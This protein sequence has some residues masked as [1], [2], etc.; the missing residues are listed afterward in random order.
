MEFN[1]TNYHCYIFDLD[2]TLCNI[3]HRLHYIKHDEPDEENIHPYK[4]PDWDGFNEACDKDEPIIPIINL[5]RLLSNTHYIVLCS[6]RMG[7]NSVRKKTENWLKKHGI[8]YA[9]LYMRKEGCYDSDHIVKEKMYNIINNDYHIAGVFDDRKS[10]VDMWRSK[11]LIC[12]Q[13][14]DGAF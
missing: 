2:G 1:Q 10:V 14:A 9:A 3:E 12:Y 13:V 5:C 6:E 8:S 11:G 4:K 7:T